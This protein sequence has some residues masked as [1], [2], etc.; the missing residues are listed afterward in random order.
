MEGRPLLTILSAADILLEDTDLEALA[1]ALV[2]IGGG[3][4]WSPDIVP[5]DEGGING[6]VLVGFAMRQ[7][8]IVGVDNEF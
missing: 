7:A 5:T 2:V 4:S 6:S 1:G 3:S 8:L